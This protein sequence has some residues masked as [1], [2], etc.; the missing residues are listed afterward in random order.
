MSRIYYG[1]E[2]LIS[3]GMDTI[4]VPPFAEQ[5]CKKKYPLILPFFAVYMQTVV[6]PASRVGKLGIMNTGTFSAKQDCKE[7]VT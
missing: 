4:I 1:V 7:I 6:L 3:C 2:Y 5:L